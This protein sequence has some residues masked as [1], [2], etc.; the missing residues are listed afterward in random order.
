MPTAAICIASTMNAT[1][2][3]DSSV[4]SLVRCSTSSQTTASDGSP[5]A[6]RSAA[7]AAAEITLST[8]STA[9]DPTRGIS[10][11]LR[12][13]MIT[14]ASSRATSHRIRSPSGFRAAPS[15]RT[16]FSTESEPQSTSITRSARSRGAT[17][18]R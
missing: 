10:S 12:S 17:I 9:I 2:L 3:T 13:P 11:S 5:G 18:R 15:N 4:L 6:A 14:L 7:S 1:K 16:T 8:V